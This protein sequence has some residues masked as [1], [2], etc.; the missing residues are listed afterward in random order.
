MK[1]FDDLQVPIC[2][3]SKLESEEWNNL[4]IKSKE[5]LFCTSAT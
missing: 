3:R 2:V 5:T 1:Y 4:R